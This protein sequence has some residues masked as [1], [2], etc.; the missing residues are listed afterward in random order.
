MLTPIAIDLL[1][2]DVNDV[3]YRYDTSRR[4]DVFAELTQTT[5]GAV[6]LAVFESGVEHRSDTGE[7]APD[8]YL[9]AIGRRLGRQVDR[10]TWTRA[11]VAATSP[12]RES[13]ALVSRARSHVATVG[14]SNN[15]LLV[16]EQAPTIYPVLAE[17]EIDLYVSAEF[18]GEKPDAGVYQGL[19]ERLGVAA[20][21]AAFVD[22]RSANA[23]GATAAGLIGHHFTTVG[24]L[25]DFLRDLG[26]PT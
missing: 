26:V 20:H 9:D 22:D 10:D 24:A 19:C 18:G 8:E 14:L 23:D 15:G 13:I 1:I 17:L 4:I 12:M 5:P 2:L 6:R 25:A 16:K 11:M 7:L 21:R 3:I